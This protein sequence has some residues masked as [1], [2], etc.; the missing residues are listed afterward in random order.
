MLLRLQCEMHKT[1]ISAFSRVM[2]TKFGMLVYGI[3]INFFPF[4]NF[5]FF[6]SYF[7]LIQHSL[8]KVFF[9]PSFSVWSHVL[10]TT[11]YSSPAIKNPRH[12]NVCLDL[13]MALS[14]IVVLWQ[15]LMNSSL[16]WI[17]YGRLCV[18]ERKMSVISCRYI[19]DMGLC[20]ARLI[21]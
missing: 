18:W 13:C 7:F 14:S 15:V 17:Y 19:L 20:D 21:L 8:W 3:I 4:S 16:N 1:E 11:C 10:L 9:S 2:K 12:V 6:S 5:P